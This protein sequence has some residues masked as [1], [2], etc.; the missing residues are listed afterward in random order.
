MKLGHSDPGWEKVVVVAAAGASTTVP[1]M[2]GEAAEVGDEVVEEVAGSVFD[3]VSKSGAALRPAICLA[4][5]HSS[6]GFSNR[7]DEHPLTF[8]LAPTKA[9]LFIIHSFTLIAKSLVVV[10]QPSR[11]VAKGTATA[12]NRCNST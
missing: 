2:V 5:P 1:A 8:L 9:R 12:Q 3:Q 4:A 11:G 6:A 10:I 7:F